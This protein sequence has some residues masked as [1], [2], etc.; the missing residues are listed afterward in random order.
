M[1][2]SMP[3]SLCLDGV[4]L[5]FIAF[6][7]SIFRIREKGIFSYFCPHRMKFLKK[8]GGKYLLLSLV[9]Q[10]GCSE[11]TFYWQF[12]PF[13]LLLLSMNINKME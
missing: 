5:L 11:R 10:M 3:R 4:S 1:I 7:L 12:K 8:I 9:L 6:D 13:F 2:V